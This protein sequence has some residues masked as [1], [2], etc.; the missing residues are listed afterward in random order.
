MIHTVPNGRGREGPLATSPSAFLPLSKVGWLLITY[1]EVRWMSGRT[2]ISGKGL[3]P[4]AAAAA[5]VMRK[6]SLMG[7]A[8]RAHSRVGVTKSYKII[9]VAQPMS[10]QSVELFH[11]PTHSGTSF[12]FLLLNESNDGQTWT[13]IC[14]RWMPPCWVCLICA[15]NNVQ[16]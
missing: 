2:N 10:I 6:K 14:F 5:G 13:Q 9:K 8:T 15:G 16:I 12:V 4:P 3:A 1:I 7:D 11:K